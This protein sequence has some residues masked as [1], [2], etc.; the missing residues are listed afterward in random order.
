M[1]VDQ[2][3]VRD[4]KGRAYAKANDEQGN[5]RACDVRLKFDC[6]TESKETQNANDVT[7]YNDLHPHAFDREHA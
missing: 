1:E 4:V 7:W 2:E 5:L 3:P 6:P